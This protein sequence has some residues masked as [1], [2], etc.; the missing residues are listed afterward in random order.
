MGFKTNFMNVLLGGGNQLI[1]TMNIQ[2][3]REYTET[4]EAVGEANRQ[5]N[6]TLADNKQA[7]ENFIAFLKYIKARPEQF[8]GD[9]DRRLSG[10]YQDNPG[11]FK[12]DGFDAIKDKVAKE[13]VT[14]RLDTERL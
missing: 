4:R 13:L 10:L 9:W 1:D 6:N 3:Q 2:A 7:N 8:S 14:Y 12:G 5:W 11:L